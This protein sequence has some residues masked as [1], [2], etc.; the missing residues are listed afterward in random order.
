MTKINVTITHSPKV[1]EWQRE[2]Y[3]IHNEHSGKTLWVS[4]EDFEY[5]QNWSKPTPESN[6]RNNF[7]QDLG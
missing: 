2:G 1:H 6:I 4:K 5:I 7:L 3:F